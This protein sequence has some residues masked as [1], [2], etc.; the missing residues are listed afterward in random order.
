LSNYDNLWLI[1]HSLSDL[2]SHSIF[3]E[4]VYIAHFNKYNNQLKHVLT[5]T[6]MW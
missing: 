2:A 1:T 4:Y 6:K 5:K 3:S